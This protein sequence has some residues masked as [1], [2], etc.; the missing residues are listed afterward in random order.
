MAKTQKVRIEVPVLLYVDVEI[1]ARTLDVE[2][3]AR[4]VVG[5]WLNDVDG[6]TIDNTLHGE[7]THARICFADSFDI[8]TDDCFKVVDE[9]EG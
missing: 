9:G 1:D 5:D 7:L 6:F 4:R 2:E 3:A 8:E